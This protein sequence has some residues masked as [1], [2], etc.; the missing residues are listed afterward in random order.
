MAGPWLAGDPRLCH[1][2]FMLRGLFGATLLMLSCDDSTA[3]VAPH[4]CTHAGQ[5]VVCRGPGETCAATSECDR[6]LVC[7][8]GEL[9]EDLE[10]GL[11]R[12][13]AEEG[14][15]CGFTHAPEAILG[16]ALA[17]E[18]DGIDRGDCA[19]GLACAP[20][21]PPPGGDEAPPECAP[22]KGVPCFFSGLCRVAGSLPQGAPCAR[23]EAC[24]SGV[25]AI[26][27]EPLSVVP[28][29]GFDQTGKWI[30]PHVGRC[31]GASDAIVTC[32]RGI[33]C[34]E[35]MSCLDRRCVPPHTLRPGEFCSDP[36]G[37]ECAFGLTCQDDVCMRLP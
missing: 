22:E 14:A 33:P 21:F 19:A 8:Q 4:V 34:A 9:P 17:P 6:G 7:N 35:G 28:L 13:P 2:H 18:Y 30:G 3:P 29:P 31:I 37:A 16:R 12:A 27:E 26:F 5:T 11:C 15:R 23:S 32:G 1:P 25:C 36:G 20:L 24:A 10:T